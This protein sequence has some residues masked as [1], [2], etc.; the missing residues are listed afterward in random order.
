MFDLFGHRF[1]FRIGKTSSHSTRFSVCISIFIC[2]PL[3]ILF[4]FLLIGVLERTTPHINVQ[5]MDVI[6]RPTI[7]L[8]ANNYRMGLKFQTKAGLTL[9]PSEISLYFEV[10]A[11]HI[12]INNTA[13]GQFIEEEREYKFTNCQKSDFIDFEDYYEINLRKAICISNHSFNLEGYW[14]ESK[15]SYGNIQLRLCDQSLNPLCKSREEIWNMFQ[16]G[17]I[18]ILSET[19][20]FF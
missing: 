11:K 10:K 3:L 6:K 9:D 8:N 4:F 12:V 7:T 14:D 20:I 13:T 15:F 16:G 17:Y 1:F 2:I 18:Y 5:E 19:H